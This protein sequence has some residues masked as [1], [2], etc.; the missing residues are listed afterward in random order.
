MEVIST[1]QLN[2]EWPERRTV[3]AP[4]TGLDE[5]TEYA[6]ATGVSVSVGSGLELVLSMSVSMSIVDLY[7]A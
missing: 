1:D 5:N 7:S 2:V 3:D 4:D 6:T